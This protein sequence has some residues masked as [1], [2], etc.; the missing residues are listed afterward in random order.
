MRISDRCGAYL[1]V[2]G[3]SV[4]CLAVTSVSGANGS[5]PLADRRAECKVFSAVEM[6][7]GSHRRA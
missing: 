3:I 6:H 2:L 1:L 5:P 4:T 7:L